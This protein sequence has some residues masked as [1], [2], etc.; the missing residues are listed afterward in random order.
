MSARAPEEQRDRR[1]KQEPANQL[2]RRLV[3]RVRPF[4]RINVRGPVG[5]LRPSGAFALFGG[6]ALARVLDRGTHD[7]FFRRELSEERT[8]LLDLIDASLHDQS[9]ALMKERVG[10]RWRDQSARLGLRA[11]K[12]RQL[13]SRRSPKTALSPN[14]PTTCAICASRAARWSCTTTTC[15]PTTMIASFTCGSRRGCVS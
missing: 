2:P 9:L 14:G 1:G 15:L 10:R 11:P 8:Q 5:P 7:A 6:G 12:T 13:G 4:P 3:R